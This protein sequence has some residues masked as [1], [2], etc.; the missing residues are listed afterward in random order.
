MT[1]HLD[2]IEAILN[3]IL[4]CLRNHPDLTDRSL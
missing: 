4:A 3:E 1:T 2:E